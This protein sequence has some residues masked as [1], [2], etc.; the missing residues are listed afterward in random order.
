M[1]VLI[2]GELLHA[3]RWAA[4]L[5]Q[6]GFPVLRGQTGEDIAGVPAGVLIVGATRD[7]APAS[8][9]AWWRNAGRTEPVLIVGRDLPQ[10]ALPEEVVAR[11]RCAETPLSGRLRLGEEVVVD[12]E[13]QRVRSPRGEELAL[14]AQ[15][16]R[17]LAALA[18]TG[19]IWSRQQLL[20]EV[21]GYATSVVTRAVD[22]AVMRVRDKIEPD[23]QVPRFLLTERGAGYRLAGAHTE[24][25]D[26]IQP[27]PVRTDVIGRAAELGAITSAFARGARLVTLVGPAG[28]GKGALAASLP[29]SWSATSDELDSD[30]S[31][32][33]STLRR[34]GT[35]PG[36]IAA[37]D[38]GAVR[39][40]LEAVWEGASQARFL[41]TSAL[42]LGHPHEQLVAVGGLP[43]EAA[44]QLFLARA[45][46]LGE[47]VSEPVA[48]E[49]AARLAGHPLALETAAARLRLVSA[50]ELLERLPDLVSA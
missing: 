42:P 12:L 44:T 29:A 40:W 43:L 7:P 13:R 9:R 31:S 37:L 45:A 26:E 4:A 8:F 35:T 5:R 19:S 16:T 21:W 32:A 50:D 27:V 11:V 34:R 49:I 38:P 15:E 48:R 20:E 41:V 39:R 28:I 17:L 22:N 24:P 14:T 25:A 3:E 46:A 10:E 30:P 47:P 33:I 23:P 18:R 6:A 36:R 1:R 2:L